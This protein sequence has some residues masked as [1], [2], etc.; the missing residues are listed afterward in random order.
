MGNPV[1][2]V[3]SE[4]AGSCKGGG[5]F[6]ETPIHTTP[7][8]NTPPTLS[9]HRGWAMGR[10]RGVRGEGEKISTASIA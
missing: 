10:G 4:E 1:G 9:S 3:P 7:Q 5:E 6:L 8:R 2:H